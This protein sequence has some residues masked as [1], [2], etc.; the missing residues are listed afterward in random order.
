MTSRQRGFAL[1]IVLWSMALIAL[2]GTEVT[3]AGHGE[4]RLATNLRAS[5][6]AEAAADGAVYEAIYHLLDGSSAHWPPDGA[7]RRVQLPQAAVDVSM[8]DEGRKLTLNNSSLP[9]LR[10]LIHA[11][12]ADPATVLTLADEIAD[13][14]SPSN[15]PLPHGAKAPQYR[16]AGRDYGPPNQP[17]RSVDELALVLHMTPEILARLRPY[18][19]PYVESTPKLEGADPVIAQ[20]LTDAAAG[21][22]PP[23]SFD[24][25]VTVTITA[26]AVSA[27]G[28][29]FTRRAVVRLNGD[30]AANPTAPQYIVLDWD[31]GSS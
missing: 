5:A 14:R 27:G 19:S 30:L 29:R 11:I 10:G 26:V 3:A 1:L 18:V 13:W 17:F 6:V 4:T 21:G 20:T 22:V 2:I 31:Q 7:V 12:G 23:L 8:A 28:A 16:A 9:L 24:E 25:P 15:S